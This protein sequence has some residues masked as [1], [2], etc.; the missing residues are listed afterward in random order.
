LTQAL[1]DELGESQVVAA[2]LV[3]SSDG[4]N[5]KYYQMDVTDKD[6]YEQIV[7]ENDVDYILHLAAILS[8]LGEKHPQMAYDVNVTGATNAMNIARDYN[9]QLFCPSSIAAFGGDNF[10][11]DNT[12]NDVIL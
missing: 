2:D 6:K 4:V 9:C 7:K 8:S 5:C 12:P 1:I 3:E 10:P 11:K